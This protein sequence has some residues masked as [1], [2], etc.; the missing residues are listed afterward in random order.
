MFDKDFSRPV[1]E[2]ILIPIGALNAIRAAEEEG[3]QQ[4]EAATARLP[5][6]A[7]MRARE[8]TRPLSTLAMLS[9]LE[10]RDEVMEARRRRRRKGGAAG[11]G[12][13][14]NLPR[15][16]IDGGGGGGGG[17]NW[18]R[19]PGSGKLADISQVA[20]AG[21]AALG[22]AGLSVL[23]AESALNGGEERA[24]EAG[25]EKLAGAGEITVP[26]GDVSATA[27]SQAAAPSGPWFDY[28]AFG[29]RI[30]AAQEQYAAAQLAAAEAERI[31]IAAENKAAET[32][33]AE[34]EALRLAQLDAKAKAAEEAEA[35][36]LA[37]AEADRIA[38]EEAEAA[39]L[40]AAEADARR[41]AEAEA[42][43]E[44]IRLAEAEAAAEAEAKRL[45][46]Q[47][48]RDDAAARQLAEA[49]AA[50]EQAKQEKLAAARAAEAK[51]LADAEAARQAR[52][53]EV[54]EASASAA[55]SRARVALS[56]DA[57]ARAAVEN[58]RGPL[59]APASLK[60]AKPA[61]LQAALPETPAETT[62]AVTRTAN[63]PGEALRPRRLDPAPDAS[64]AASEARMRRAVQESP[65]RVD[66]FMVERM[67]KTA[68]APIASPE[69][70]D[71]R[72]FFLDV[73][74]DTPDGQT[75]T[76]ETPD[77]R[78]V[79]VTIEQT[80]P[81][82]VSQPVVRPINYTA[83]TRTE[84]LRYVADVR[85]AKATILCKDVNYAFPGQERGRFAACPDGNGDWTISR[86]SETG[87]LSGA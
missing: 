65:Q 10:Q 86:A 69:L 13:V 67:Q 7:R 1:P 46:E 81:I 6:K 36:R 71:F 64:A 29:S 59:P 9:Q 32:A 66:L 48:A 84:A 15:N 80:R 3:R 19:A 58:Y 5:F 76:G 31:R 14:P 41:Q 60:P 56:A 21:L 38:A 72:A 28:L 11:R 24:D 35:Q 34:A 51:R 68:Q 74:R 37:D 50:A 52:E 55:S 33:A 2:S 57:A 17:S 47:Q 39:R 73:L 85:P 43:A 78:T 79:L 44:R 27:L 16:A 61:G 82:V 30:E 26:A 53:A 62:M 25:G 40:A 70:V 8:N 23:A 63:V 22:L 77:G 42:E 49:E 54:A 12:D 75:V 45:A 20:F 83:A 18:S 4:M 87:G